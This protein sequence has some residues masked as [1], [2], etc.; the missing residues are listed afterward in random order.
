MSLAY[1]SLCNI[2]VVY[3]ALYILYIYSISSLCVSREMVYMQIL[4]LH[5]PMD[6][7]FWYCLLFMRFP[8]LKNK[9]A[10]FEKD[11]RLIFKRFGKICLL[12]KQISM[13]TSLWDFSS[14]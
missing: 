12:S 13:K 1:S 3:N 4:S 6:F 7:V 2:S 9:Q 14:L 11:E 5:L 8:D 10:L